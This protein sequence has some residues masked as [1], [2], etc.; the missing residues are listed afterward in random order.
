MRLHFEGYTKRERLHTLVEG[1]GDLDFEAFT[2]GELEDDLGVGQEGIEHCQVT[3]VRDVPLFFDGMTH[4][5]R[6][7]EYA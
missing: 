5:D 4:S 3:K 7:G 1:L 6:W 2:G